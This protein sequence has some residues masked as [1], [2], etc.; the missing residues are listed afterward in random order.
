MFLDYETQECYAAYKTREL[1]TLGYVRVPSPVKLGVSKELLDAYEA[2]K[3]A[4]LDRLTGVKQVDEMEERAEKIISTDL[5]KA[6]EKVYVRKMGY[7]PMSMLYQIINKLF[8]E[9]KS[10]IIVGEIAAR[11][12]L[13]K[14]VSGQW[15]MSGVSAKKNKPN[16]L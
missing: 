1:L 3:D 2:K 8:P 9:F 4:H 10:S 14:E 7:I 11:I 16:G 5:F 13:N 6:A 15:E 12:K